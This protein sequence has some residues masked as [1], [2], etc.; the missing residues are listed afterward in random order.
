MHDA[1]KIKPALLQRLQEI[2]DARAMGYLLRK[3]TSREWNQPKRKKYAAV[4]KAKR[5]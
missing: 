4:N 1:A 2:K 3:A 5:S